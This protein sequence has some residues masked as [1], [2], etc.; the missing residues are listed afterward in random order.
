MLEY[1]V[2]MG[3]NMQIFSDEFEKI[4]GE[5]ERL[6][7]YGRIPKY[8]KNYLGHVIDHKKMVFLAWLY[9]RMPLYYTGHIDEDEIDIIDELI[10]K[11][12][13]SKL[14]KT[15]FYPYSKRFNGP[16]QNDPKVKANFKEA[17]RVH[18]MNNLHHFETL[19]SYEGKDWKA[20]AIELICDYIAMGWEFDNYIFE[21]F[22][23]AKD[24]MSQ[25]LPEE[26]YDYI[27]NI[28]NIIPKD[29]P[30]AEEHLTVDNIGCVIF[31]GDSYNDP[32]ENYDNEVE[33]PV[34]RS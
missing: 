15:E 5:Y 18:K 33:Q 19:A 31:L 22:Q 32:V 12:D 27:E 34:C 30:L 8:N 17:V 3:A 4:M 24:E 1:K 14:S 6:L 25:L 28:I 23:K 2:L 20:Y 9:L 11:H 7:K 29:F 21:F 13:D 16:K 10:K 26:R